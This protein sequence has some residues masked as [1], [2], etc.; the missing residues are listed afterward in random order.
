MQQKLNVLNQTVQQLRDQVRTLLEENTSEGIGEAPRNLC[1][2]LINNTGYNV[3]LYSFR[4]FNSDFFFLKKTSNVASQNN[5]NIKKLKI[6]PYSKYH[7][8]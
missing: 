4:K 3:R 7:V 6:R 8:R 2:D 1:S 5:M